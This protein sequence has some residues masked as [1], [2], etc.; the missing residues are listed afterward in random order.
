MN[1]PEPNADNQLKLLALGLIDSRTAQW[2]A[3]TP[4]RFTGTYRLLADAITYKLCKGEAPG[5][6]RPEFESYLKQEKKFNGHEIASHFPAH[7][8][9]TVLTAKIRPDAFHIV[10][11]ELEQY[12]TQRD[13]RERGAA[14]IR[15]GD[16]QTGLAM[17]AESGVT[18][19]RLQAISSALVATDDAEI[20]PPE[21]DPFAEQVTIPL[22]RQRLPAPISDIIDYL[23]VRTSEKPS[24]KHLVCAAA[25]LSSAIGK[26]VKFHNW[27]TDYY[28]NFAAVCLDQS[29]SNKTGLYNTTFR[30][31][32]E[33]RQT[34]AP[35]TATIEAFVENYCEHVPADKKRSSEETR[36]LKAAIYEKHDAK[37]NG[38]LVLIDE[39][40]AF[41]LTMVPAEQAIRNGQ[42]FCRLLDAAPVEM[43]TIT[44]GVRVLG[45]TPFTFL[46]FSQAD[47]WNTEVRNVTQQAGGLAGRIV[48]VNSAR[49]GMTG[50]HAEPADDEKC[51]KWLLAA[52]RVRPGGQTANDSDPFGIV[53]EA[54]ACWPASDTITVTFG[55]GDGLGAV[56]E[57][58]RSQP[59]PIY[60]AKNSRAEYDLLEPKILI[61]AAKFASILAVAQAIETNALASVLDASKWLK[62]SFAVIGLSH[63]TNLYHEAQLTEQGQKLDKVLA[64][65]RRRH[66]ATK[67]DIVRS[68]NM[69]SMEVDNAIALLIG[70][71][72]VIRKKHGKTD[73]YFLRR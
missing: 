30:L 15:A 66:G 59:H 27:G 21:V 69:K 46:G 23:A 42:I 28:T 8:G 64:F 2:I 61:Q 50:Y 53:S 6:S 72:E 36:R 7:N 32:S 35:A 67:R 18:E 51:R 9:A 62:V 29:G 55:N 20:M 34:Y 71:G 60:A 4:Q 47:P 41:L 73:A 10:S 17:L 68:T 63:L 39:F 38:E 33:L 25:I 14:L 57:W 19:S 11:A 44:S 26:N 65:V 3:E 24:V 45:S 5:I 16:H 56:K 58:F 1:K 54:P 48:P 43:A 12:C 13:N 70:S 40:R 49:F 37:R 52:S 31:V 22:S